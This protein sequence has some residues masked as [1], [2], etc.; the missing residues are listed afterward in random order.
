[1]MCWWQLHLIHRTL[2]ANGI[3]AGTQRRVQHAGYA[4]PAAIATTGAHIG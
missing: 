4:E 1:M 3:D 2:G